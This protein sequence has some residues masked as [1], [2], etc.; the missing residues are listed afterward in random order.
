MTPP[1]TDPIPAADRA[2]RVLIVR[3]GSLGD[4]VHGLPVA[5]ALRDAWPGARI[6]WLVDRAYASL[7]G[8]V[9][10]LDDVLVLEGGTPA[11]WLRAVRVLRGRRYDIALDLQGLLKSA[12]LARA[13]GAARVIG[14]S[15][16]HLRERAAAPFYTETVDP[17]AGGHIVFRT[18]MLL[19][20]VGLEDPPLRFPVRDVESRVL[21]EVR[22]ELGSAPFALVN[23]GA[24]W[25]NKRW[26]PERFGTVAAFLGER[27]GLRS[28]VVWG[29]GE[30]ALAAQVAASSKGFAR[31][32]PPTSIADLA[33]LARAATL[34]ISGDTGPL[35]LAA[36]VGTPIVGLFGPTDPRRNGP[37][38][39]E[40]DVV[41][42]YPACECPYE[43]VCRARVWCLGTVT[44]EEVMVAVDERLARER[45]PERPGADAAG[46]AASAPSR[47]WSST[48]ESPIG[49]KRP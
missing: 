35:H 38:S 22:A 36:A 42:A 1:P 48:G 41:S 6:D 33:A 18:L 40:D 14:F 5:A 15:D 19:R 13:S 32:A 29:P 25:P 17:G 3:L 47:P 27:H 12:V 8:L 44:P 43:R 9:P 7:L 23:P 4:I 24:A 2:P 49:S 39:P 16:G 26:P 37:W 10:V 46:A 34:M 45:R 30:D 31:V 11:A 21:A 28:V 20:A